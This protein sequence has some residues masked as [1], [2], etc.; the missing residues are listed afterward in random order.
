MFQQIFK[1]TLSCDIL[2][3]QDWMDCLWI[4]LG[5][6]ASEPLIVDTILLLYVQIIV[7]IVIQKMTI[8]KSNFILKVVFTFHILLFQPSGAY[9]RDYG[10]SGSRGLSQPR[11]YGGSV[12]YILIQSSFSYKLMLSIMCLLIKRIRACVPKTVQQH[13]DSTSSKSCTFAE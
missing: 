12:S 13:I 11:N 8:I 2:V 1:Q 4:Q 5:V 10:G 3:Q 7:F 9:A 6:Y